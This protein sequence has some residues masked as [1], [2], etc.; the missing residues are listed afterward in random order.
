MYLPERVVVTY[1]YGREGKRFN[2]FHCHG[3]W[4]GVVI[5]FDQVANVQDNEK[6]KSSDDNQ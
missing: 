6:N 5:V 4:C 1:G 3:D 2:I